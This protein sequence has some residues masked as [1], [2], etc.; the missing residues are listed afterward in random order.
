M[1]GHA[2]QPWRER[3][4]VIPGMYVGDHINL[5][6]LVPPDSDL[7]EDEGCDH[8]GTRHVCISN[9]ECPESR[10]VQFIE[11]FSDAEK[12]AIADTVDT[13]DLMRPRKPSL[14]DVVMKWLKS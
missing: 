7:C 3:S 2:Q 5:G 4:K 10:E 12:R 13:R 14:L 9:T 8:H 11:E 1:D 6:I